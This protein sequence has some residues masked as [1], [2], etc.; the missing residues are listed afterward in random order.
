MPHTTSLRLIPHF[1]V[2]LVAAS[3]MAGCVGGQSNT[4]GDAAAPKTSTKPLRM[5][6]YLKPDVLSPFAPIQGGN[7]DVMS[8]VY[9]GL[10]RFDKDTKLVPA[11]AESYEVSPDAK[12]FTF[13]LRKDAKW[14]DGKPV[15]AQDVVFT[16]TLYVDKTVNSSA[17]GGYSG[18]T[19]VKD[20]K[21]GKATSV[22]GF[23]ATDEHTFVM[24]TDAPNAGIVALMARNPILPEHAVKDL[25]KDKLQTDPWFNNPVAS[26]PYKVAEFKPD[27]HVHLTAVDRWRSKVGIKD[28]YLNPV[29]ADVATAQLSS[30]EI[31][32]AKISPNDLDTV[33]AIKGLRLE[34]TPDPGFVRMAVNQTQT[35]FQ[36]P[37]VRQAMLHAIDRKGIVS[38]AL[39]DKGSVRN[40]TFG[41][42]FA[43]D[44]INEYAYDPTKAKALLAEAGWD[45]SKPVNVSWVAGGNAD[46]DAAA[47]VIEQ[48]FNAVGIKTKLNRIQAPQQLE[49]L[50]KKTYDLV[51]MGG[52]QY[53]TDGYSVYGITGCDRWL[54]AGGNITYFCDEKLDALMKKANQTQD[55]AA[56]TQ[57]YK[58]ASMVENAAVP[59][60]YLYSPTA[61]FAVT[62]KLKGFAAIPTG[63]GYVDP[64][65]WTLTD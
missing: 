14:S 21:E 28:I 27:Q 15:T 20:F 42:R 5:S 40:T 63:G 7:T 13:H 56:R 34:E 57:L 37:R 33:K 11:L 1:A 53:N 60:I 32:V 36:D 55:E 3:A 23:K 2:A 25:P 4:T 46:R 29:T 16:S 38:S 31:D 65:S 47:V 17:A 45:S 18:V 6:L 58:E 26:G 8:L 41:P 51:L 22:A 48:Q 19:G 62:D 64:A 43:G 54:P 35:R 61:V 44:G 50:Q 24:T 52:G 9:E 12:T 49:S 30:G 59:Y 39:K 10:L